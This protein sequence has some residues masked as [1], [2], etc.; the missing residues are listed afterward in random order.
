VRVGEYYASEHES[1]CLSLAE[2]RESV[3]AKAL[4]P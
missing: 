2:S 4:T 3:P 1:M